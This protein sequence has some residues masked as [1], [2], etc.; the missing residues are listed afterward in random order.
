MEPGFLCK[1]GYLVW[2]LFNFLHYKVY[3]LTEKV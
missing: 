2:L 1:S 3:L